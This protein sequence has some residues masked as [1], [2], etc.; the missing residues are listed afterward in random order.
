VL[1]DRFEWLAAE[2]EYR[3]A[4]D[5]NPGEAESQ[6]QYAQ[7]L[8]KVGHLNAAMEHAN[9]ARELD[10]L[11][12]VP[13]SIVGVIHLSRGEFE[14]CRE[15]LDRSE[16]LRERLEGFQIRLELLYALSKG[17]GTLARRALTMA[18]S[19]SAGEWSLPSNKKLVETMDQALV[20]ASNPSGP[21]PNFG[22]ALEEAE[23]LGEPSIGLALAA[24]DEIAHALVRLDYV[25]GD[26]ASRPKNET[27]SSQTRNHFWV[28][29]TCR[30]SPNSFGIRNL[31]WR[32]ISWH[33]GCIEH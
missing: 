31:P 33:A 7:M 19:S 17:N 10:P 13:P 24:V 9:R 12:W 21:P 27:V 1:R 28:R 2:A 5:L 14:Q 3:R 22:R 30:A 15:S 32:F 11:A 25:A 6:N 4:L 23:T 29:A 18:R 20:Y 26:I 8:L 16:K